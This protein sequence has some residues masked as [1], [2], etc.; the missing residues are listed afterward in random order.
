MSK[1]KPFQCPKCKAFSGDDWSQCGGSCPLPGTPHY[2]KNLSE[3]KTLLTCERC[4]KTDE[5][6]RERRDPFMWEI[7]DKE[8]MITYCDE[9]TSDRR[10][11]I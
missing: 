5:T 2:D 11:E 3:D 4:E 1:E 7:H 8:V 6:V 9:C 10:E